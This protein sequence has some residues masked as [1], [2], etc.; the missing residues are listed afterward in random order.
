MGK[1]GIKEEEKRNNTSEQAS[2]C[3]INRGETR[4]NAGKRGGRL[5][6]VVALASNEPVSA[7][8]GSGRASAQPPP[9]KVVI[10][11]GISAN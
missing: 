2:N 7:E 9:Q 8:T 4:E 10:K 11:M 5:L 1:K 6:H 3:I